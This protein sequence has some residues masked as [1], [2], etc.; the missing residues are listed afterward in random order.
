M[1]NGISVLINTFNEEKNIQNCLESVKWADEIIL[2][3]MY[4]D[5]ETVNIAKKYTDKI[6]FFEKCGYADPAR[7]FALEKANCNW[8]LVVDADELVPIALKNRLLKIA[9][10]DLAD[11]VLIPRM[12]FVFGHLFKFTGSGPLQDAQLRFFKKGYMAFS[13]AIHQIYNI[14]NDA[15]IFK[16]DKENESFIHFA[17]VSVEQWIE[18]MDRYSTI[19]ANNVFNDIKTNITFKGLFIKSLKNFIKKYFIQKGY[20]EGEFGFLWILL[21]L[22]YFNISY[23]KLKL[24]EKFDTL[25]PE[26]KIRDE[27]Q[28]I[29]KK[30]LDEYNKS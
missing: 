16:I 26:E 13:P 3:D 7:N 18:K 27:Y 4:S 5:D 28:Q 24:M 8:I 10:N 1:K 21:E 15:R 22:A 19:E 30:I 11:V 14:N 6:Y 9:E 20:K 12:N 2:V 25:N 29:T 17:Y 23:I